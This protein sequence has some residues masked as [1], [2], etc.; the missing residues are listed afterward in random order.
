[1]TAFLLV[2]VGGALGAGARYLVATA[3]ARAFGTGFPAG[4]AIVN[5]SGSFILGAVAAAALRGGMGEPARLFLGPGLMGGYTTYSSFNWET[6]AL[7]EGRRL[8]AAAA[9][10][11][12]TVAGCLAA[13]ALGA[14]VGGGF[15]AP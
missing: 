15:H 13:A 6:L 8:P 3:V 14:A 12:I 2:C 7:L 4:T 5:L 11:G 10:L 1:V 9:N